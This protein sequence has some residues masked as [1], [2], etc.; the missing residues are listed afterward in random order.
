ML[1]G[2][3]PRTLY[4]LREAWA[5]LDDWEHMHRFADMHDIGDAMVRAR[6]SDVVVDSERLT[7][8][9]DD[10][11]SLLVEVRGIGGGNRADLRRPGLT[12]TSMLR[13]LTARY[14]DAGGYVNASIELV[15]AHAWL[16]QRPGVAIAGPENLLST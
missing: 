8:E 2:Y 1:V 10:V 15:F 9:F 12:T 16:T 5:A 11:R 3:G 14:P 4:E 13:A 6:L 7:V